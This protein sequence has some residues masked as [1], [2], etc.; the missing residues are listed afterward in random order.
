MENAIPSF[1]I[2]GPSRTG[3]SSL[4]YKILQY[5]QDRGFSAGGVITLQN[6]ARWFYLIQSRKKVPFEA[7]DE[8][9]S[10]EIGKFQ[11]SKPNLEYAISHI[12]DAKDL[13]FLFIDEIGILEMNGGGYFPVLEMSVSRAYG[14]IFIVRESI[15]DIFKT[16]FNLKFDYDILHCSYD[17]N[18]SHLSHM[19]RKIDKDFN[20]Q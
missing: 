2:T 3:K 7:T 4:G 16:R 9:Q 5:I 6:S 18:S 11:I 8:E 13:D 10:V 20:I 14:N 1:L 12:K 15:F 17:N 19:K